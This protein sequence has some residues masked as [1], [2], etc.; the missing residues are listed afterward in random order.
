MRLNKMVV[1]LFYNSIGLQSCVNNAQL[2]H[3]SRKKENK[4]VKD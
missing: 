1:K 4:N 3:K 2:K